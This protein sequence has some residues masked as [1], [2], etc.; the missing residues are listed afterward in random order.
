MRIYQDRSDST[1][2]ITDPLMERITELSKDHHWY[3]NEG[4]RLDAEGRRRDAIRYYEEAVA[5]SPDFYQA[6]VNLL[7]AYGMLG[8]ADKAG[9]HYRRAVEINPS[10]PELHYNWGVFQASL[11][12]YTDAEQAFR[13]A[14]ELNPQFADAHQNLGTTLEQLDRRQDAIAHYREALRHDPNQRVAHFHLGRAL[15]DEGRVA[16][17]IVHLQQALSRE[18]LRSPSIHF[19][20]AMAYV[21]MDDFGAAATHGRKAVELARKYGQLDFA[22]SIDGDVRE[23]EQLSRAR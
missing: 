8:D 6:H 15:V 7:G 21:R 5:I 9:E 13:R 16:E 3:L 10:I 17:G 2:V 20:L 23:L 1:P 19:A 14:L 11:E 18:D 12:R 4:R 22:A